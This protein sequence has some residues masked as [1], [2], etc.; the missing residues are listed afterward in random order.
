MG[1]L[2][3]AFNKWFEES[4]SVQWAVCSGGFAFFIIVMVAVV[5]GCSAQKTMVVKDEYGHTRTMYCDTRLQTQLNLTPDELAAAVKACKVEPVGQLIIDEQGCS[6]RNVE[7][8]WL[9]DDVKKIK[10]ALD[11]PE[12]R[13]VRLERIL[14]EH[15]MEATKKK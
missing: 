9:D 2:I 15:K 5:T 13:V 10:E 14:K 4:T 8:L 3:N 7:N 1:K 11:T 6:Y 12:V